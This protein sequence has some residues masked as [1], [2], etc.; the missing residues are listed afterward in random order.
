[1]DVPLRIENILVS[2]FLTHFGPFKI[3]LILKVDVQMVDMS[4]RDSF[5]HILILHLLTHFS[6]ILYFV[7]FILYFVFCIPVEGCAIMTQLRW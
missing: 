7:F 4:V 6:P 2:Q 1:M 5:L 3:A